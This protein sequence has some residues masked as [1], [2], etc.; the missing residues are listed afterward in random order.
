[1]VFVGTR[2]SIHPM[3]GLTRLLIVLLVLA[4]LP[5]RGYATV[6]AALCDA[7]HG[8]M[9]ATELATHDAAGGHDRH[10]D[11][12]KSDPADHASVC[13]FCA[14]CSV[15]AT[16]APDAAHTVAIAATG[17]TPIPFDGTAMLGRVP[18]VL[19]RPPLSL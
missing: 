12:G 5:L 6:V 3:R 10:A 19:D 2:D 17:A 18:V 16:L 14:S 15:S 11:S 4:A 1:M 9:A 7:H 8:G 13:S